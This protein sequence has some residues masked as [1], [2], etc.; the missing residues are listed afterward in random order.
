MIMWG[1]PWRG[2]PATRFQASYRVRSARDLESPSAARIVILRS[3]VLT[4][5]QRVTD[6]HAAC[7][8]L[9]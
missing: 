8:A 1:F 2:F 7:S 6:G 4:H 3:L 9:E 5:Y